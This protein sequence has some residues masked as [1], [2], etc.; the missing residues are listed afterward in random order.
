VAANGTNWL[1]VWQDLRNAGTTTNDIY[2]ARLSG[3]GVVLDNGGIAI[4]TAVNNQS[5]PAVAAN[6]PDWLVVWRDNRSGGSYDIYGASV[7]G[8][9]AVLD[10]A[11]F[12]INT[13]LE[14][15]LNPAVAELNNQHLVVYDS[16]SG[17]GVR[18]IRANLVL[19]PYLYIAIQPASR[20]NDAGTDATF[21]VTVNGTA[22]LSYQWIKNDTTYLTDAGNVSGATTS[23]LTL[24]NVQ[25]T[26][27]GSY[28]VRVSNPVGAMTSS[29]ATLTVNLPFKIISA[30]L[31]DG[32]N[33]VFAGSGGSAGATYYVLASTNLAEWLTNW[34]CV[35]TNTFEL[36]GTFN[37]TN[38]VDLAKP[39]EFFRLQVP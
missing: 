16:P 4:S 30:T 24:A 15:Q 3:S 17:T 33:L 26:D 8:S 2:A 38:A 12:A 6:G 11:G 7:N 13:N 9:G 32:S 36:D 27:A 20:T 23:A 31:L 25:D 39:T 19:V 14:N 34:A 5:S 10:A 22:P 28:S 21:T 18:G 37:V 29:N 35:A 1:V